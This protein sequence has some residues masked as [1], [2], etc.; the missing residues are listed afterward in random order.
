MRSPERSSKPILQ[1]VDQALSHSVELHQI[2]LL[3]FDVIPAHIIPDGPAKLIGGAN[4]FQREKR[5][6]PGRALLKKRR[7]RR[8][9]CRPRRVANSIQRIAKIGESMRINLS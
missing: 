3:Q 2:A 8:L 6:Y 1:F 4:S 9:L 5:R 7:R